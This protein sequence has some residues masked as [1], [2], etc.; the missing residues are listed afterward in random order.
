MLADQGPE[1]LSHAYYDYLKALLCHEKMELLK[2]EEEYANLEFC[3]EMD[4]I[5]KQLKVSCVAGR[6]SSNP[7]DHSPFKTCTYDS[8]TVKNSYPLELPIVMEFEY[9]MK[10]YIREAR[11]LKFEML[12]KL[13]ALKWE[14]AGRIQPPRLEICDSTDVGRL[15]ICSQPHI[16]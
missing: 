4:A 7:K 10:K 5:G 16:V 11:A 14:C 15:N 6:K 3:M 8:L 12:K 9:D 1:N 13:I 2:F